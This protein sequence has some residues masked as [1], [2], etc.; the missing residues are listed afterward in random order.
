MNFQSKDLAKDELLIKSLCQNV[1]VHWV[2][3]KAVRIP[4]VS[5]GMR[6]CSTALG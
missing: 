3:C 6:V 1:T 4:G 5:G 2:L